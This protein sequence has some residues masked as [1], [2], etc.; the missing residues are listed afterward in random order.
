MGVA[1]GNLTDAAFEQTFPA[2][3]A[4]PQ[5]ANA[6]LR[7]FW[8]AVGSAETNLLASHKTFNNNA[9][10][11]PDPPHLRDDPRRTHLACVAAQPQGSSRRFCSDSGAAGLQTP[12]INGWS[13]DRP[14]DA[15]KIRPV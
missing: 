4:D 13:L 12:L 2:L 14:I 5:A 3:F 9:R 1:G 8:A 15:P 7:L 6:T 11:S 10:P